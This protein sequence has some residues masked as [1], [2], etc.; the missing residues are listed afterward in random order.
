MEVTQAAEQMDA[1]DV[2]AVVETLWPLPL[3]LS[4]SVEED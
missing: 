3:L 4:V 2:T 1:L